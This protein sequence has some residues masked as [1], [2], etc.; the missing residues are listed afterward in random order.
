[1]CRTQTDIASE[2]V[3]DRFRYFRIETQTPRAFRVIY[4][5]SRTQHMFSVLYFS[6]GGKRDCCQRENQ[7][8]TRLNLD[9]IQNRAARAHLPN[10]CLSV[11]SAKRL[12]A[13]LQRQVFTF[14]RIALAHRIWFGLNANGR[15]FMKKRGAMHARPQ[16][17]RN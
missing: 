13:C 17:M 1:M 11:N 2:S 16:K 9:A 10:H 5:R 6:R 14:Q 7:L 15:H 4:F 3:V 8:E 12:A